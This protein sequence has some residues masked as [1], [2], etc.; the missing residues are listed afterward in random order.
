MECVGQ[1]G[2][3]TCWQ[4]ESEFLRL[5]PCLRN[6]VSRKF[7]P[8]ICTL[9]PYNAQISDLSTNFGSFY[10]TVYSDDGV[11][12]GKEKILKSNPIE[13]TE[14]LNIYDYLGDQK[15][16]LQNLDFNATDYSESIRANQKRLEE[17]KEQL[18]E[19]AKSNSR[20]AE[21]L[22]KDAGVPATT[23]NENE[24]AI[25]WII[26]GFNLLPY[27]IGL[28]TLIRT[29][30]SFLSRIV[31]YN[32]ILIDG[33]EAFSFEMPTINSVSSS[34]KSL[35][36]KFSLSVTI[37]FI[38]KTALV[39]SNYAI[40]VVLTVLITYLT[41]RLLFLRVNINA[42]QG[43]IRSTSQQR[44]KTFLSITSITKQNHL[45]SVSLE[46]VNLLYEIELGA[47]SVHL[48]D[49][50]AYWLRELNG[51][52]LAP[53]ISLHFTD[54]AESVTVRASKT[55]ICWKAEKKFSLEKL[56]LRKAHLR[57]VQLVN[58]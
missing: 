20:T 10:Q 43:V 37:G 2:K 9:S 27:V 45:F 33:A 50:A 30:F 22:F 42:Y 25:N 44:R 46:R 47:Q 21:D 19:Q 14:A 53:T 39:V 35:I 15:Q 11:L 56:H 40:L 49:E 41:L 28:L 5:E 38:K 3:K 16:S 4:D 54:R 26:V 48:A 8:N 32:S 31:L 57:L 7:E 13:V 23:P 17:L 18:D 24:G 51:L 29:N 12:F 52:R 34:A 58:Q 6:I 55:Q 1:L 36:T